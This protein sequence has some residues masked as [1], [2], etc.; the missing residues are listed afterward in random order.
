MKALKDLFDLLTT[1][2]FLGIIRNIFTGGFGVIVPIAFVLQVALQIACSMLF[3]DLSTAGTV[4]VAFGLCCAHLFIGMLISLQP[5]SGMG[6]KPTYNDELSFIKLAT[7][8]S[9][10]GGGLCA[11]VVVGTASFVTGAT[12]AVFAQTLLLSTVG[13]L[14]IHLFGVVFPI[15][16]ASRS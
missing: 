1:I 4:A 8:I 6:P 9:L 16:R 2:P 3:L 10:I 14:A 12:L 7:S 13:A 15:I 11:L 5:L